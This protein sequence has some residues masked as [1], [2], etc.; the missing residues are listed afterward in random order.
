[1]GIAFAFAMVPCCT[2]DGLYCSFQCNS[3]SRHAAV[4]HRAGHLP[5]ND[6]FAQN[7]PLW[8]VHVTHLSLLCLPLLFYRCHCLPCSGRCE[9]RIFCICGILRQ[10]RTVYPDTAGGDAY[11]YDYARR[12]WPVAFRHWGPFPNCAKAPQFRLG[13]YLKHL[14]PPLAFA[15][16]S[17]PL[18]CLRM[19]H[20]PNVSPH[21]LQTGPLLCRGHSHKINALHLTLMGSP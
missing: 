7:L 5:T 19:S 9:T 14:P 20:S 1:M 10:T 15:F 11:I 12:W 21:S 3:Q 2:T 4:R 18:V 17:P 6:P 8:C 13:S 16:V